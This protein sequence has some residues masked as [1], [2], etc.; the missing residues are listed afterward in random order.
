MGDEPK[1][2]MNESFTLVGDKNQNSSKNPLDLSKKQP[3]DTKLQ[4]QETENDMD[5]LVRPHMILKPKNSSPFLI[6]DIMNKEHKNSTSSSI[7]LK[8][9]GQNDE[10]EINASSGSSSQTNLTN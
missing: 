4:P 10:M 1:H 3:T 6:N 9:Q 8:L 7:P 5:P 2:K